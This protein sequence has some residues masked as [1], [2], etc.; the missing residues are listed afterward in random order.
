[1][2]NGNRSITERHLPPSAYEAI[3]S[4]K[5]RRWGVRGSYSGTI[6]SQKVKLGVRGSDRWDS[7]RIAGP[8]RS[9]AR[10][11]G[12]SEPSLSHRIRSSSHEPQATKRRQCNKV[13]P[14]EL[15]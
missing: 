5:R 13:L 4:T 9:A 15:R 12:T 14:E 2:P 3:A 8:D 11:M 6:G 1:M 10:P 7:A